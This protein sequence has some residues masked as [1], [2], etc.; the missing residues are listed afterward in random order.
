MSRL[1]ELEWDLDPLF[2][3]HL[4]ISVT[5]SPCLL[6]T[7]LTSFLCFNTL[8]IIYHLLPCTYHT[9][10]S[11][12]MPII[13]ITGAAGFVGQLLAER[14]LL[15]PQNE[16]I[17]TDIISP[18]IPTKAKH[19]SNAKSIQADLCDASSLENLISTSSPLDAVYIFHG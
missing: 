2:S 1:S 4:H 7:S 8:Y 14:L 17:L 13:L 18:P 9:F 10:N 5:A 3:G 16:L 19:A 15:Q 12:T 6:S 11:V